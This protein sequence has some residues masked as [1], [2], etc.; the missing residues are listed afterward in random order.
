VLGAL[1]HRDFLIAAAFYRDQGVHVGVSRS[2]DGDLVDGVLAR[3]GYGASA[4]G[5]SSRGG[6]ASQRALLE[7]LEGGG[8]AAVVVDGPRGPAGTPKPG[9]VQLASRSKRPIQPV[10]F[11]A[12][13]AWHFGSWDRACLPLPFARI[14]CRYAEPLAINA[15]PAADEVL[16]EL[17]RRLHRVSDPQ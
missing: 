14:E 3:L 16:E 1:L 15:S 11:V 12:R 2:R 13:P 17:A 5:S 9:V 6:A 8:S 10:S 4:R 7:R